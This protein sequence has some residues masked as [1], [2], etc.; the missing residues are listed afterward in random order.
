MNLGGFMF[1]EEINDQIIKKI[2][3]DFS[4]LREYLVIYLNLLMKFYDNIKIREKL[5]NFIKDY[6]HYSFLEYKLLLQIKSLKNEESKE[7]CNKIL[8]ELDVLFQRH[9][10]Y[11]EYIYNSFQEAIEDRN[12]NRAFVIKREFESLPEKK[13]SY[14]KRISR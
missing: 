12:I 13:D 3:Y 7:E 1:K 9:F 2:E 6:Y 14:I 4:F 8:L 11:N 10:Q 5:N